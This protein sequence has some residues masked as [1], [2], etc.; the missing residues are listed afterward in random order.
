MPSTV[1]SVT[2]GLEDLSSSIV[3]DN[4]GVFVV[5]THAVANA[6]T[7]A[8]YTMFTTASTASSSAQVQ[9]DYL[10][11]YTLASVGAAADFCNAFDVSGANAFNSAANQNQTATFVDTSDK[12]RDILKLALLSSGS[13]ARAAL[14]QPSA[15]GADLVDGQSVAQNEYINT[16]LTKRLNYII[17]NI[18]DVA[19]DTAY[20]PTAVSGNPG[21]PASQV[22][23]QDIDITLDTS[24]GVAVL[25]IS[26]AAANGAAA[27]G[28]LYADA[29]VLAL[30]IPGS[31]M[32][33]YADGSGN[34]PTSLL[35]K[36]GDKVVVAFSVK[37][38]NIATTSDNASTSS[39]AINAGRARNTH[40]LALNATP[41]SVNINAARPV[42]IAVRLTMPGTAG[43]KLASIRAVGEQHPSHSS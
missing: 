32:V 14:S 23:N 41:L 33:L 10:Y 37:L 16:T 29:T 21:A 7:S 28:P 31:N 15:A 27:D 4:S 26:G 36:S 17:N 42:S 11:D 5:P 39:D 22:D 19:F 40:P 25:D 1:D 2:T 35:L 13:G 9:F 6:T 3:T 38:G 43:A 24:S 20:Y 30:Q 8:H 12:V 34:L 18:A